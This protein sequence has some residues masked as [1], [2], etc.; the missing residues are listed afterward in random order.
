MTSLATFQIL[1]Y[2]CPLFTDRLL[3]YRVVLLLM[4]RNFYDVHV[5]LNP[6]MMSNIQ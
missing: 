2:C 3:F 6:L 1:L 5:R 4:Q